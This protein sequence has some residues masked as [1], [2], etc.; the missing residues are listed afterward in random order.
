[1]QRGAMFEKVVLVDGRGH[2]LGRLAAVIAKE[3]LNGQHVTIVRCEGVNISGSLF[4]NQLKFTEFLQK[5]TNTNPARG[6]IH[7]RAPGR[8]VARTI[9][10]MI[11]H[12]TDRGQA[13]MG[14]LKV[15]EGIPHPYDKMKRKVIPAALRY[16]RLR[17][18]RKFCSVGELANSFGWK[19]QAL[20]EKLETKR[21]LKSSAY[22]TT[23]KELGRVKAKSTDGVA[24]QLRPIQAALATYGYAPAELKKEEKAPETK[25]PPKGDA[26]PKAAATA[27]ATSDD[28]AP[29]KAGKPKAAAKAAP[30]D[31]PAA[32]EAPKEEKG[33][34]GKGKK[35][36]GGGGDAAEAPKEKAK[37]GKKGGEGG[38]APKKGPKGG[39]KGAAPAE[40]TD[41]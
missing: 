16:I 5:R 17:P 15:F 26:P 34:G 20:I 28:A 1:L 4:R 27:A 2:M 19:H 22:H 40:P 8:I 13:A 33:K 37:G 36:G 35:G 41:D 32:A 12:K 9:R 18:G 30:A 6:P 21:K 7:Q 3:L 24:D 11:P 39:K 29:K 10:G 31:E 25:R 14:R 23:K 38:D